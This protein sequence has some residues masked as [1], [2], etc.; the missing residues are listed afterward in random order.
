[1]VRA[2]F[3]TVMKDKLA[4]WACFVWEGLFDEAVSV[5]RTVFWGFWVVPITCWAMEILLCEG[6]ERGE[7][8]EEK[9][10]DHGEIEFVELAHEPKLPEI[11]CRSTEMT[12]V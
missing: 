1:M 10:Q 11:G 4:A 2:I 8:G 12:P 7:H 6:G 5:V 3:F 9:R